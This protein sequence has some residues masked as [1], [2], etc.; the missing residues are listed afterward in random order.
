MNLLVLMADQLAGT[1]M[2]GGP[3]SWIPA[4]NL[5]RLYDQSVRFERAYCASPLCTP[6]RAAL[7][8]GLLPSETGV[9]DNAAELPATIPTFAHRLR[10]LGQLTI[11]CGKMHFVGPDQLHGFE[12][13]LTTD[14]Y[15]ADFGWTPDWSRPDQRI[16]WW[17]HNL[18]SV[19]EAGTAITTN[20]LEF[21]DEVAYRT[22]LRLHQLA[23]RAET[24]PFTLVASFTH[25]HD[26]YVARPEFWDLVPE[27]TVPMPEVGE[28]E[29]DPHSRRLAAVADGDKYSI[30]PHHV[31][32]ARRAYGANVAYLDR[33]IGEILQTLADC[34][35]AR[36]T[37]VLFLA[38]HGDFLGERGLWFKMSFLEPSSRVPLWLKLPE[39]LAPRRVA[40]PVSLLDVGDTLVELAGGGPGRGLLPLARGERIAARPVAG[41]YMAEGAVAPMV[42]LVE[43]GW[44]YIHAPPD[45]PLLFEL[46]SDPLELRNRADDPAEAGRL[47][48][49]Q[50][51][52]ARRWDLDALDARIRES[53]RRRLLAHDAL[54]R[55]RRQSWDHAPSDDVSRRFM[56]NHLDLDELETTS[57][58]PRAEA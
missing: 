42:M 4:P 31:L 54:S 51:A 7:M 6:S 24:R 13:R 50:S 49:F 20:Q 56:R 9:Y 11:L 25:P 45:P 12:E 10:A 34:D 29:A 41:E 16:D 14:I 27:A 30:L 19:T 46:E 2:A 52:V 47:A 8:T 15:P 53:Q 18:C 17:Y 35:F 39:G 43:G 48:D 58:Y 22:K 23:R 33:H 37:A 21:D 40:T 26:P 57:R 44:K 28:A 32:A 1:L 36:D 5:R 55:G 38:D 3:A